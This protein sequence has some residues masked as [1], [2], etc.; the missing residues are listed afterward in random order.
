MLKEQGK[1]VFS[2]HIYRNFI[3]LVVLFYVL[4]WYEIQGVTESIIQIRITS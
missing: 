1:K 2:C 4:S 3:W